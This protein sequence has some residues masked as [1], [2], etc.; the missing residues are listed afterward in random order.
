[1]TQSKLTTSRPSRGAATP[2]PEDRPHM[3][4]ARAAVSGVEE[5]KIPL[6]APVKYHKALQ[7]MKSMTAQSVPVK[8]LLLEAIDDLIEKYERGEGRHKVE[9]LPELRRRL[10]AV[11]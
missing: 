7:E 9:D 11:K 8:H 1:M 3:E 6:L 2:P 4:K 10:Q 5:K